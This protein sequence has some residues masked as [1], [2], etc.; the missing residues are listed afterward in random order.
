MCDDLEATSSW[1]DDTLGPLAADEPGAAQLRHTLYEFLSNGG[2]YIAA[3]AQLHMHRN[4]VAY[5]IHK[6][7]ELLQERAGIPAR[8]RERAGTVPLARSRGA[9]AG[10]NPG[11]TAVIESEPADHV[12]PATRDRQCHTHSSVDVCAGRP[13]RSRAHIA[14][15][16][17]ARSSHPPVMRP[18]GHCA[19]GPALPRL[20]CAVSPM[21]SARR[22]PTVEAGWM[23]EGRRHT[24]DRKTQPPTMCR[25]GLCLAHSPHPGKDIDGSHRE[26]ARPGS[27][28]SDA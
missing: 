20:L 25:S 28:T 27:T 2:S 9:H 17:S 10:R 8:P 22:K 5:R 19:D 23:P 18:P 7:E 26:A 13:N 14:P 6:A 24:P 11:P 12:A 4:S 16:G 1:V 21:E 3:A 15:A